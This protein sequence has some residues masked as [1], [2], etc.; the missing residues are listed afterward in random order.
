MTDDELD[1]RHHLPDPTKRTLEALNREIENL[2]EKTDDAFDFR[3]KLTA[4]SLAHI[5]LRFQL[6]EA[7]RI[8][9]K[10]DTKQAVV[11]ALSA[12]KEA[13][14]E[15]TTASDRSIAKS[16]TATNKQLEQQYSTFTAALTGLDDKNT[17]LKDR[18]ARVESELKSRMTIIESVKKGATDNTMALYAAAAALVGVVA[19][20]IAIIK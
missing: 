11:D 9:Q 5:E 17:D 16:E 4:Q 10:A 12:Q 1:R 18:I 19:I 14:K 3:E 2:E 8:E 6:I 15:Q 7:A 13:V 20:V